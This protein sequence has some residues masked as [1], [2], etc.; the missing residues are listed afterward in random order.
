MYCK[1]SII[2]LK[3]NGQKIILFVGVLKQVK[4]VRYLI[5]AMTAIKQKEPMARLLIVGDGEE[6]QTLEELT[7][8]LNLRG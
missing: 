8:G 4:V 1:V 7:E 5:E 2:I 3:W 6:R